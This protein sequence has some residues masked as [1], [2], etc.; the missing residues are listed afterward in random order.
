MREEFPADGNFRTLAF[1]FSEIAQHVIL[2]G[3]GVIRPWICRF[4]AVI[5]AWMPG[6]GRARG[7]GCEASAKQESDRFR[8]GFA[9]TP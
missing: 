6:Q 8:F 4:E 2:T 1:C 5:T 3:V 7:N 9:A